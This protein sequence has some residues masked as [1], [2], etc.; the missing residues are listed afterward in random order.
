MKNG[1]VGF[2]RSLVL[3]LLVVSFGLMA[4]LGCGSGNGLGS[5]EG[6]YVNRASG[7]YSKAD[8]TLEVVSFA[9]G[10]FVVKRR[11]GYQRVVDGKPGPREYGQEKWLADW[12]RN[13]RV[14]VETRRGK[15]LRFFPE[16]GLLMVGERR[17]LKLSD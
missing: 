3:V 8:D 2:G 17:Y 6:V 11:T 15:V 1:C 7:K 16:S 5:V 10:R 4:G 12:D 9:E 13:R 14:L